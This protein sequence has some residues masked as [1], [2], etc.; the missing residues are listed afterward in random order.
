MYFNH[1]GKVKIKIGIAKG[2]KFTI[3]E[4]MRQNEIGDDKNKGSCVN[5]SNMISLEKFRNFLCD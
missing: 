3:N 5:L 4:P 2:K 1:T